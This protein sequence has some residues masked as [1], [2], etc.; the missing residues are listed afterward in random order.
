M[1]SLLIAFVV[2]VLVPLF[3]A[4]W[5]TS[6][7]GLSM[8][9]VLL[10]A[11][12]HRL[13]ETG[14]TVEGV[15]TFLDL[16]VLRGALA[17]LLLYGVLRARQVPGRNDVVPANALAWAGA[18]GLVLLGLRLGAALVPIEGDEQVLVGVVACAILIGFLV[19]A[20]RVSV[21]SQ[22]IGALRI[23]NAVALFELGLEPGEGSSPALKVGLMVVYAASV[24]LFRW[25][26]ASIAPEPEPAPD[27]EEVYE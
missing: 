16:L 9:G 20:T 5:R 3:V 10:F 14:P 6:L 21:F 8:Q 12:A 1:T 17:P 4:S 13:G 18:I 11:I 24:G 23:E 7:L 25:Y 27:L 15:L 26:L 19:L 2:V 22:I